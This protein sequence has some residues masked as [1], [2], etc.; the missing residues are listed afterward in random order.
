MPKTTTNP[1]TQNIRNSYISLTSG[2]GFIS[3]VSGL[4]SL[5]PS[6]GV[7]PLFTAGADGSI[8]KGITVATDEATIRNVAFYT[9][10]DGGA[11][12][13]LLGS[14]QIPVTAGFAANIANID[15][16]NNAYLV[17]LPIDQTSRQCLP[18]ASGSSVWAG[19]VTTA[20]SINKGVHIQAFGEDF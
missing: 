14:V 4:A 19:M 18:L 15:V 2:S 5:S 9:S 12:K 3:S 1:F 10:S 16:L 6:S 17:G 20:V 8:L 13:F 11:S 7:Y